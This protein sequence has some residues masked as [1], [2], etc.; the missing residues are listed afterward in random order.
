MKTNAELQ[1][2]VI[3]ELSYEPSIDA[4]NIGVA[5]KDGVITLSGTVS[6]Y[7]DKEGAEH[8]A[9]RVCGVKAVADETTVDLPVFHKRNDQEIALAAVNALSWQVTV[10]EGAIKV[11]VEDGWLTLD[12]EVEQQ[13]QRTAANDAVR[14]LLGVLGVNNL[15]VLKP[16]VNASDLKTKIEEAFVRA[17]E[18]DAATIGLTVIGNRVELTGKVRSWA[19]RNEAERAAWSA[20]GVWQVENH[21]QI[22]VQ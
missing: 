18:V 12:G 1:Q 22:A 15:I 20:P 6:G 21:L 16:A 2:D 13:F 19:E 5:A 11:R 4:T 14:Q 10:P 17:A 3:A 8:A 9:E 7:R